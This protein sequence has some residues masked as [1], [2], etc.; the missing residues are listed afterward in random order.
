MIGKGSALSSGVYSHPR[1]P[2]QE[3]GRAIRIVKPRMRREARDTGQGIITLEYP[4]LIRLH[5]LC[6]IPPMF[7]VVADREDLPAMA[8]F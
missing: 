7:W 1:N 3:F 2:W 4:N 6:V 5:I 8:G